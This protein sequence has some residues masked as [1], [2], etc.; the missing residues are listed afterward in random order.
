MAPILAIDVPHTR[1]IYHITYVISHNLS[2]SEIMTT[3]ATSL[4]KALPK[5]KYTGEHEEL[6]RHTQ[7]KGPRILGAGALDESQ[8]ALK[9][10]SRISRDG[11]YSC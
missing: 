6:P 3:I 7:S 4:A 1:G 11:D 5:A 9:V 10:S 2:I 8:I